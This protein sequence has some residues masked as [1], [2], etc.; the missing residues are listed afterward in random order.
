MC[1]KKK[2]EINAASLTELQQAL[3]QGYIES[4]AENLKYAEMCLAADNEVLLVAG[5]EK[6]SEC[7]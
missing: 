2:K 1:S 5:E 3:K 7:E 6:I 4:G